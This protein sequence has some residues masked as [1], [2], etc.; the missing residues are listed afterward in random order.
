MIRKYSH[1]ER[2][3]RTLSGEKPDRIPI[4]F[5]RHFPVDDQTPE[6]LA[7]A[8]INFQ[9][10]Y[11]FDFVKVT[12][13]SSF[14]L[15]DWGSRDT[16]RG[17][18]EGTRDYLEPVINS[19]EDYKVITVLDPKKGKLNDQ[20]KCLGLLSEAL[21]DSTPLIQTV[22]SPLSQLKNLVGK[23]NI[24]SFIR[25]FPNETLS[26]LGNISQTTIQFIDECKI[27]NI[28]GIFYAV[29]Q[30]SYDHLSEK[31]YVDFGKRF[32]LEIL[33]STS[34][35]WMN[36]LHMHGT[37]IMFDLLKDYPC[38]ILNWHDR[39]TAPSL[40][41]AHSLTDKVLCGGLRRIETMVFGDSAIIKDEITDAIQQTDSKRF[42]LSTGCVLL[43]TT[44]QGNLESACSFVKSSLA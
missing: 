24:G 6:G 29:Q 17:N 30:A 27:R 28:D 37:N 36:V 16:W 41:E 31:E 8:V 9:N 25:R 21:P 2:M 19:I 23:N 22:F 42:I 13:S 32:D 43:Q 20:L 33:S 26:I 39:E 35:L 14:C 34:D 38:Q 10:H 4:S 5:W 3:E 7:K 11:D 1:R 15:Y 40:K 18:P 12:P 44:P